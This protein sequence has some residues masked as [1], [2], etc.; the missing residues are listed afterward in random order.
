MIKPARSAN[1][2]LLAAFLLILSACRYTAGEPIRSPD[3]LPTEQPILVYFTDPE[4]DSLR[5]GPDARLADAIR[6]AEISVDMAVLELNL[7]SVRDALLDAQR[8]GVT[9]RVVIDSDYRDA[10][11][12]QDLLRA[13][14]PVLGDRREGLM[15]HK[16]TI[17]DRREVWTGSMNYTI[18][19]GYRNNNHLVRIQ[20]D[21]L[22]QNYLVEFNEMFEYD[23]FG[24]GS[25]ANTPNPQVDAGGIPLSVC[26]S[27]DDGCSR[28]LADRLRAARKSI[29]FLAFSFTSDAL[30]DV[31]IERARAGVPVAGVM[32]ASQVRSNSG[33]EFERF[34][35]AGIDVRKDGN[36]RNM[37]HKALII[38]SRFVVIGSYNFSYFAETRNDENLVIIDD[39]ATA[40]LFEVEFQ[41]LIAQAER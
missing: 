37:H 28:L 8:R 19:D 11:E 15:H 6:T 41:K 23:Q 40:A 22:A 38:D 20:S 1:R 34:R 35:A 33:T 4:S 31:L 26:F 25:P 16:F 7:W 9:V 21:A 14:I 24:P 5:G 17:I 3:P 2:L 13:G 10:N 18:S 32:E 36:P 39:A 30:G 27:P 12:V 29:H